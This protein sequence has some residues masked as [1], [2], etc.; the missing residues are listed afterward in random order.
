MIQ[1]FSKKS[2]G[3]NEFPRKILKEFAVELATPYCNIINCSIKSGV[4]PDEY[5]KAE[6]TPIPKVNPPMSL[7]DL[8]SI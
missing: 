3:I 5:R 6:I 2:L 1:K 8:I 4:F 7:S